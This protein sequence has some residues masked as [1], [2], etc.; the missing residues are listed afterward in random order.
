MD[1]AVVHGLLFGGL[2]SF[3]FACGAFFQRRRV[4]KPFS[5]DMAKRINN[6][7]G[8]I[9]FDPEAEIQ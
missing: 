4:I 2:F 8:D 3:G 7:V 1:V 6:L 9:E 5:P